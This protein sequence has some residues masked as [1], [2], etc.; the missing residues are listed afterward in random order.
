MNHTLTEVHEL[1]QFAEERL[2]AHLNLINTNTSPNEG[3]EYRR[4][5]FNEHLIVYI[6]ELNQKC[7]EI[8]GGDCEGGSKSLHTIVNEFQNKFMSQY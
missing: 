7:K 6:D 3:K 2:A 8:S 5:I 1:R 4:R